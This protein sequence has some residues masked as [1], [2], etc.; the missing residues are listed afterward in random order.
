MLVVGQPIHRDNNRAIPWE[1]ESMTRKQKAVIIGTLLGDGFLQKTGKNNAR[2]R[3][4]HSLKQED[5]LLWKIQILDNYFQSKPQYLERNNIKFGNSYQYIRAQSYS[6][7]E[8][9]KLLKLFYLNGVKVIPK[10]ILN[11]LKDPLSLA[12]WFMDDGYFYPRDKIAY[13]YLPKYDSDSVNNILTV[14]KV[15]FD[16]SPVLKIKKRGEYV[17]IFTVQETMKL[18]DI[19]KSF[20]IPSMNYKLSSQKILSDPVSTDSKKE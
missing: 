3:L 2:L 19:I 20:V 13:I 4:E 5:Y 15:N 7:S 17:L 9:G 8:F 16:L 14:L 18:M 11:L 1:V 6:G 12:I 10:E